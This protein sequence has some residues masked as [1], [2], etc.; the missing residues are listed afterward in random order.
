MPPLPIIE[1]N[2]FDF[3]LYRYTPKPG[4]VVV[5][6]GAG[7]GEEVWTFSRLVGPTGR[8]IAVEAHPTTVEILRRN[9]RRWGL[10]NVT[11]LHAA[12]AVETGTRR[13]ADDGAKESNRLILAGGLA[14]PAMTFD[15]LLDTTGV[16]KVDLLKMNIEG[17]EREVL[18]GATRLHQVSNAAVECHDFLADAGGEPSLATSADIERLFRAADFDVSFHPPDDMRSWA[19]YYIYAAR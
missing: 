19:R 5:D 17:A 1:M 13:I 14:V 16:A 15:Q 8:V 18:R 12:L 11:I 10:S 3:F 9:V 4:D 7:A 6:V 2:T